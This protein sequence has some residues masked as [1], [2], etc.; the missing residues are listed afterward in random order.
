MQL[1]T[2]AIVSNGIS[3]G[4]PGIALTMYTSARVP[5][6]R[7]CSL[8]SSMPAERASISPFRL[9]SLAYA[10]SSV[11]ICRGRPQAHMELRKTT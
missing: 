4:W 5:S 9:C 11:E 3:E 2:V 10:C 6:E 7:N 1:N 8:I